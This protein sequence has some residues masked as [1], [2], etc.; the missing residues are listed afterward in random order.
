MEIDLEERRQ[1]LEKLVDGVRAALSSRSESDAEAPNSSNDP[2]FSRMQQGYR[3]ELD[4]T[5]QELANYQQM[6]LTLVD[7][8]IL[9]SR[10]TPDDGGQLEDTGP[11]VS[12]WVPP[13]PRIR[14]ETV[15]PGVAEQAG[16]QQQLSRI[17]FILGGLL[18]AVALLLVVL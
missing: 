18:V 16:R 4:E 8:A 3:K 9:R 15:T 5:S 7:Q 6:L 11:W 10:E 14:H 2:K 13:P 12:A 1:D 17:L